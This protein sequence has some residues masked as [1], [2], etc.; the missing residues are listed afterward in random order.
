MLHWTCAPS[1]RGRPANPSQESLSLSGS[2]HSWN[3]ETTEELSDLEEDSDQLCVTGLDDSVVEEREEEQEE[4]ERERT[5]KKMMKKN[6][7]I[8]D[9]LYMIFIYSQIRCYNDESKCE[10]NSR[11][12]PHQI[13]DS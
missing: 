6:W 5:E 1:Q 7:E 4:E 11:K 12:K 10:N 9:N 2:L 13:S 3:L 8:I